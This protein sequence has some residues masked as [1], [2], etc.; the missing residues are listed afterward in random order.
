M[1]YWIKEQ[2]VG[3]ARCGAGNCIY[4]A[5]GTVGMDKTARAVVVGESGPSGAVGGAPVCGYHRQGDCGLVAYYGFR[6]YVPETGRWLNRDPI[7]EAGGLNLY[8]VV[9]NDGVNNRYV[10]AILKVLS[11]VAF[12]ASDDA[13]FRG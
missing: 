4:D 7:E 9:G 2:A 10:G 1:G 6:Y 8:G 11:H 3:D 12:N 13:R 5:D